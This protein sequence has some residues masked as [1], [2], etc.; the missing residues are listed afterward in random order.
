M[1][2]AEARLKRTKQDLET[3]ARKLKEEAN[4]EE[5]QGQLIEYNL[6]SVEDG[7]THFFNSI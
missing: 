1:A 2:A 5:L 7:K 3:R 6:K 4:Q